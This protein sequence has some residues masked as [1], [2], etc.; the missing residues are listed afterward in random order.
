[1]RAE[2][3]PA[4]LPSRS[5]FRRL[6]F[7]CA[8]ALAFVASFARILPAADEI[9][10]KPVEAALLRVDDRPPATWNLYTA[11]KKNDRLLI[12]L[13]GRYL[14]VDTNRRRVYEL[15]PAKL[16]HKGDSIMW[17]E[18]DRPADSLP[19][20]AW[21]TRDVGEAYRIHFRLD[22]EGHVFDIDI[23]HPVVVFGP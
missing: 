14:F 16:D 15:D 2:Q 22:A 5:H 17:R 10:W 12:Q 6:I 4:A 23:P 13:G 18:S 20:S 21:I 1:V 8:A 3:N 11:G 19:E 9:E 7:A